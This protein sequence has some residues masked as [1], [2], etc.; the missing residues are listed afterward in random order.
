MSGF[1]R[2]HRS[3]ES[4]A[5]VVLCGGV[6]PST[7]PSLFQ[8]KQELRAMTLIL[9]CQLDGIC[10]SPGRY[11]SRHACEGDS[12]GVGGRG[13]STLSSFGARLN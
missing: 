9:Q 10:E 6:K 11:S 3:L 7:S 5:P 4:T 12:G 1:E 8:S 2:H 13:R